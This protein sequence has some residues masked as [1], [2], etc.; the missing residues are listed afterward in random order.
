M[1]LFDSDENGRSLWTRYLDW[2]NGRDYQSAAGETDAEIKAMQDARAQ[3]R[4]QGLVQAGANVFA[5]SMPG[6]TPAQSGAFLSQAA[7]APERFN[8]AVRAGRAEQYQAAKIGELRTKQDALRRWQMLMQSGLGSASDA[9]ADAPAGAPARMT[10]APTSSDDPTGPIYVNAVLGREVGGPGGNPR[11]RNPNS[12]AT[13]HGQF[14]ADTWLEL[15]S[16]E[17]PDLVAGKSREQVLEMRNDPALSQQMIAAYGRRN[18]VAL[19]DAGVEVSPQSALLAHGFGPGG[20]VA[21][22]RADPSTPLTR[23]LSPAAIKA[24]PQYANLT[25]ADARAEMQRRIEQVQ[26]RQQQQAQAPQAGGAPGRTVLAAP[27]A[28]AP[29]PQQAPA[30][31]FRGPLAVLNGLPPEAAEAEYRA[32]AIM[33]PAEGSKR[34]ADLARQVGTVRTLSDAESRAR[35]GDAYPPGTRV[36][37]GLDGRESIQMPPAP[38]TV[39]TPGGGSAVV[40]RD[41]NAPGGVRTVPLIEGR[42]EA[43]P[44]PHM[45]KPEAGGEIAVHPQTGEPLYGVAPDGRRMTAEE[46]APY[47]RAP[48]GAPA[49]TGGE[50]PQRRWTNAELQRGEELAK[51]FRPAHQ[52][53]VTIQNNYLSGLQSQER[54]TAADDVNLVLSYYKMRDPTS[55]VS[56]NEIGNLAGSPHLQNFLNPIDLVNR[57]RNGERLMPEQR[58]QVGEAL[59]REYTIATDNY[60][61]ER[62]DYDRNTRS[63]G[64]PALISDATA[65]ER[66]HQTETAVNRRLTARIDQS[67]LQSMSVDQFKRIDPR[68]LANDGLREIHARR[69]ATQN[70]T[71]DW[72]RDKSATQIRDA[73]RGVNLDWMHPTAREAMQRRY[74]ELSNGG[75]R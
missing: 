50:A 58:A 37:I 18:L 19:R 22:L 11:A 64:A 63:A 29:A 47:R 15:V 39:S 27:P 57:L 38:Q 13:G 74:I 73:L 65:A 44:T 49:Q 69:V 3:G 25:A 42:P 32:L 14:V 70:L 72:F 5:A 41:P 17:R 59:R 51:P 16:A 56:A 30:G 1:G 23:L 10:T 9:P 40:I 36:Q 4:W 28:A 75:T 61:R 33:S 66:V 67:Q 43:P 26:A 34:L 8:E 31:R 68:D 21:I 35:L 46:L 48:A 45:I 20:A 52:A 6:V 53:F 60:R 54:E 71:P 24:N 55:V 2:A 62:G 12:T 7:Q